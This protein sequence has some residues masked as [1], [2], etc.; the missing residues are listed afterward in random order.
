MTTYR[1]S[2]A[3]HDEELDD[4]TVISPQPR[5]IGVQSTRRTYGVDGTVLDEGRYVEIEFSYSEDPTAYAALLTLFGV[6]NTLTNLV[7]VYVPDERYAWTRYNGTAVRPEIGRDVTRTNY[8]I[9]NITILIK[10]LEAS[11]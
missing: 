2:S 4:L 10:D 11:A 8:F 3:G 9:R 6:Q 1:V 5:S 7:T